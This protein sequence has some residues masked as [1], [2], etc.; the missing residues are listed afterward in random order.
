L[1]HKQAIKLGSFVDILQPLQVLVNLQL[2]T[3]VTPHQKLALLVLLGAIGV[4]L[5]AEMMLVAR[6][7]TMSKCSK[8][9]IFE[10]SPLLEVFVSP[11]L[12]RKGHAPL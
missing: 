7:N 3:V 6:R 10:F 12:H 2:M 9:T 4:H 11:Q 8:K 1:L 5:C